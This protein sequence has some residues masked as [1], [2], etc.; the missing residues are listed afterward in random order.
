MPGKSLPIT[1]DKKIGYFLLVWLIVNVIHASFMDLH[2][3]EAYYWMYSR[4]LDVGYFDHPPIIALFIKAGDL[5]FHNTLG[6][7]LI[8]ILTGTISI[9]IL[10][11]IVKPY[12]ANAVLFILLYS[13]FFLFNLYGFIA[14]PDS[15]LLFFSV[16]FFYCYQQYLKQDTFKWVFYLSIVIAAL[17]YSKYHGILILLF[18][19]LS[20]LKLLKRSSFWIIFV[21]ALV[22]Y[23]PHILWQ[24]KNG[25]PTIT[26][27]LFDRSPGS[28]RFSFTTDYIWTQIFISAPFIGWYLFVAA[29]KAKSADLF[30]RSL[31]FTFYG[32]FIFF[33]VST[34]KGRVEAH[35]TLIGMLPLFML[36]Y[37]YLSGKNIIAPWLRWLII[38]NIILLLFIRTVFIIPVPFTQDVAVVKQHTGNKQWGKQLKEKAGENFVVFNF[39]FQEPSEYNFYNNTIKAFPYSN[40]DYRKNQFDIWP[41]EDTLRASR[42][43]YV[44]RYPHFDEGPKFWF[45]HF[46]KKVPQD[47]FI[48]KNRLQYGRW[49]EDARYY[50]KVEIDVRKMPGNWKTNELKSCELIIYNLYKDSINFTNVG[51]Q[52]KCFLEYVYLWKG[53]IMEVYS[54]GNIL[55]SV[56]IAGNEKKI[57]NIH[58]KAPSQ[59][60]NY[61]LIFSL[62]TEPFPGPRN[63]RMIGVNI[64]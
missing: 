29:C 9:Y 22:F 64:K 15:P 3:D 26:Y 36:S 8:S 31:K 18:T 5:L 34:L 41:V 20:N 56:S 38:A 2:E 19:V 62:K 39:G 46:G 45:I 54:L 48:V 33:L 42:I 37:L 61:K 23:I 47:S 24:V 17:L 30:I 12:S 40:R 55:D 14:T 53:D 1:A 28:Y 52:W 58:L 43:Y 60:G 21:L 35:W 49:I 50:H 57:I 11:K 44:S 63:S 4:Y 6:V 27:Q 10:W 25:F 13:C 7:R 16:L 51:R 59:P 32:V